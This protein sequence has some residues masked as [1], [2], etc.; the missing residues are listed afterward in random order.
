M[1]STALFFGMFLMCFKTFLWI[2]LF[3]ID[4]FLIGDLFDIDE[5]CLLVHGTKWDIIC[6][7]G[8]CG[9]I[10]WLGFDVGDDLRNSSVISIHVGVSGANVGTEA[11]MRYL[12]VGSVR[13][14]MMVLLRE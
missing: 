8:R 3:L 2:F 13:T 5:V 1:V 6:G 10:L 9:E 14:G 12:F 11:F 7:T 4:D